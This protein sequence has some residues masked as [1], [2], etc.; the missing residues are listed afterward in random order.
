MTD[1]R[2]VDESF[3]PVAAL[4]TAAELEL[5]ASARRIFGA[6][7]LA[8]GEMADALRAGDPNALIAA[9]RRLLAA[10][11]LAGSHARDLERS[12]NE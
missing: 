9:E 2:V 7:R 6:G 11:N 4:P 5:E 10:G 8:L 3:V 12:L 1:L